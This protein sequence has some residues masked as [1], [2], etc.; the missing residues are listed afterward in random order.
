MPAKAAI[1]HRNPIKA[2]FAQGFDKFSMAETVANDCRRCLAVQL[3]HHVREEPRN[4]N[5]RVT[6]RHQFATVAHFDV[7]PGH[8]VR[9]ATIF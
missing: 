7:S 2:R 3:R 9:L 1:D 4:G 6:H 8:A 5:G